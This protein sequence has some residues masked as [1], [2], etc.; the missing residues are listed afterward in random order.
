MASQLEVTDDL[1]S[2]VRQV[3]LRDDEV[4]RDLRELTLE[5]PGGEKL[6]VMA[7]EGQLLEL[8]VRLSGARRVVDVGTFT[9]Y[10]ALCLARAIPPDGTVITCDLHSRWATIAEDHWKRAGVA[11]RIDFRVGDGT[12]TLA[13]LYDE[14]GPNSFELVF[15]DADKTGYRDYYEAALRL[16][17]ANGLVVFDNT[18]LFGQVVDPAAQDPNTVAIRALNEFLHEDDRVDIVLLPMGDGITL[19]RKK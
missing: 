18:L 10:S 9:G 1:L 13:D 11:D 16:L 8:L 6:M 14:F 5:L 4:L 19:A 7:E 3:S 15:I 12:R 17:P 2:Y